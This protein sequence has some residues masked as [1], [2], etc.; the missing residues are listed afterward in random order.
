MI[1][2]K[3]TLN[4]LEDKLKEQFELLKILVES[5]DS[6]NTVVA[7][8]IATSIRVLLHDTKN[9]KSLF[10]QLGLKNKN[11]LDTSI[12]NQDGNL[13]SFHGL[14]GISVG[15]EKSKY[16][17]WLDGYPPI[18][19]NFVPFDEYWNRI[20]FVDKNKNSFSRKDII[21]NI[22][23]Q[24]GGAHVDPDID[25]KFKNLARENSLGWIGNL[26]GISYDLE[27]A[28]LAATRQI[29]HEILR[30]SLPD[31]PKKKMN[32]N[33]IAAVF[34]NIVLVAGEGANLIKN[35]FIKN[36]IPKVGRNEK[37]PCGSDLKY[38]K[39]HGK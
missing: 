26:N 6:G 4:E 35:T 31:Y 32:T 29:A 12:S 30:S 36:K 16:I 28:E 24:D 18:I 20:I 39:C 19:F 8:S 25:E 37:C 38:K 23:D 5:Y 22:A 14:M 15:N 33:G 17:P 9:S 13:S 11:F 10:G 3:Q 27:G 21:L 7:K 1:K 34:S 2:I